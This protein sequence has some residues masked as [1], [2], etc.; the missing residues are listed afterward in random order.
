MRYN[1]KNI[2]FIVRY[3]NPSHG[4]VERVTDV[5]S[6]KLETLGYK[7]FFLYGES[8]NQSIPSNKK[9]KIKLWPP[10]C[11]FMKR[12][13]R[14][15]IYNKIDIIIDQSIWSI[16]LQKIFSDLKKR[17]IRLFFFIHSSHDEEYFQNKYSLK[18]KGKN[19]DKIKR[20]LWTLLGLNV[21]RDSY[22]RYMYSVCSAVVLLSRSFVDKFAE[23]YKISDKSKFRWISN[24]LTFDE[25]IATEEI[26]N[27]GKI[28]L[29][30]SRFEEGQKNLTS[31]FRIWKLVEES[32]TDWSLKV[33][34]Y[35]EDE[36]YYKEYVS[37]LGTK[38]I[39]FLRNIGS[40][41]EYYKKAALFVMTS[42]YEGFGMTLTEALQNGCI[43]LAFD[44]YAAL[45]DII[46]DGYNDCIV[47][48]YNEEEYAS[49]I[50]ELIQNIELRK[51]MFLHALASCEKFA[52]DS[53]I[54]NWLSLLEE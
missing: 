23:K 8:D 14:F 48:P 13:M 50:V 32:I 19:I 6:R 39:E 51:S 12:V 5:V 46:R 44:T 22:F 20:T 35:G 54:S 40:V 11:L 41:Q 4:G 21:Q 9:L 34:G 16:F 27:K 2:L 37:S 30:V 15:I 31:A 18:Q 24:P 49:R 38:S 25:N 26:E 45:H 28:A 42:H 36:E 53:I 10:Y 3:L 17:G 29:I 33:I 1:K 7:C 52:S 43:P 47:K